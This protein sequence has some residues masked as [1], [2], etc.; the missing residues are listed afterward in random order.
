MNIFLNDSDLVKFPRTRH[1]P[2]SP[3]ATNDDKIHRS[4]FHFLGREV[5]VTEKLD[6]ENTT[7]TRN[8][9]H[10][11]SLSSADHW[12][13]HRVKQFFAENIQWKL[14]LKQFDDIHRISGEN[15]Q[16]VHSIKYD[17]MTSY[18][19]CF[20]ICD[21]QDNRFSWDD[22]TILADELGVTMVPLIKRG[23][24]TENFLDDII[25]NHKPA[26]GDVMEGYVMS[27][28]D[29][30]PMSEYERWVAKYVRANHVTTDQHWMKSCSDENIVIS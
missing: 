10:A 1:V 26:F 28:A 24:F 9:V 6:G 21:R 17:R 2:F 16:G 29:S 15:M 22:M 4:L 7:M 27:L 19:Y 5:I 8:S 25:V 18:F 13:R 23:I 12:T 30:F 11:R 3:G 20:S 14:K